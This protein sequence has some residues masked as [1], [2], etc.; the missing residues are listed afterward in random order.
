MYYVV[1]DDYGQ[2]SSYVRVRTFLPPD[3]DSLGPEDDPSPTALDADPPTDHEITASQSA[4]MMYYAII[5]SAWHYTQGCAQCDSTGGGFREDP[6]DLPAHKGDCNAFVWWYVKGYLG[7][8]WPHSAANRLSTAMFERF[9]ADSL[10]LGGYVAVASSA[11]R[12]G[13]VVTLTDVGGS[14][15]VGFFDGWVMDGL[16]RHPIGWANNGVPAR[17]PPHGSPRQNVSRPTGRFD[18]FAK[19]ASKETKFFRPIIP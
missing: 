9:G 7:S 2:V 10:A 19:S 12:Y 16:D 17:R 15:H 1:E 13:D 11:A 18:F 3:V 4:Y 14:G 6:Y 5:D 8:A